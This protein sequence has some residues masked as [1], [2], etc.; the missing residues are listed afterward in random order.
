MME[1]RGD[2]HQNT[3]PQDMPARPAG[4]TLPIRQT[5]CQS[6]Q[7]AMGET[8]RKAILP[9]FGDC[10][11]VCYN[12][13]GSCI[14]RY[15]QVSLSWKTATNIDVIPWAVRPDIGQHQGQDAGMQPPFVML[16]DESIT[17]VYSGAIAFGP[18]TAQVG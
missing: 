15:K 10:G 16:P 4:E 5:E 1:R 12:P 11:G 9:D 14:K 8:R 6:R 17:V 13:Q 18:L 3:L 7:Q 2:P